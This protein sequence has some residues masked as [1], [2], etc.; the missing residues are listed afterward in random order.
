MQVQN[1][2]LIENSQPEISSDQLNF[3]TEARFAAGRPFKPSVPSN[4]DPAA[5]FFFNAVT[6]GTNSYS[7]LQRTIYYISTTTLTTT[8]TT[9]CIPAGSFDS[10]SSTI[11]CRRKRREIINILLNNPESAELL[12][13]N[14]Q[15]LSPTKTL[16]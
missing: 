14:D 4:D 9:S 6:S 11:T 16:P 12:S 5:R 10:P 3:D 2:V 7:F 1:S 15:E 13:K 8:S